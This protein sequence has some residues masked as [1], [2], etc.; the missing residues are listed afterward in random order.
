[1]HEHSFTQELVKVVLGA[2]EKYPGSKPRRVSVKIGEVYHLVPESVQ[3]HYAALT[4]GTG[5]EHAKLELTEI[6]LRVTCRSCGCEGPVEDHHFP[7][8]SGCAS[9]E[10]DVLEG[11]RLY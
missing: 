2:L 6:P 11:D 7:I 1:M 8:C 10:V 5:L 4:Q 9:T 3:L